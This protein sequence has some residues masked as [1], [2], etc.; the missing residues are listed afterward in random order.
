MSLLKNLFESQEPIIIQYAFKEPKQT[1]YFRR[2][3]NAPLKNI[4][5]NHI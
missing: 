2:F 3:S 4:W 1:F 5:K